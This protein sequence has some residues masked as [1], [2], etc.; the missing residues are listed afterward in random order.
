MKSLHDYHPLVIFIYFFAV[1]GLTMFYMHPLLLTISFFGS[2]ILSLFIQRQAFLATAKWILPFMFIAALLNPLLTHDGEIILLYVNEQP[3]T[4]EAIVYGFA[5]SMML[6]SVIFWFGSFN[7]IMTSD[8]FLYVFAKISPAVALLISLT[9]RLIP[10]FTHQIKRITNAQKAIGMDP[11]TGSLWH[12]IKAA[13]RIISILISWALENAIETADSMKARGYGLKNRSTFSLF[14]FDKADGFFVCIVTILF[15]SQVAFS[16]FGWNHFDYYPTFSALQWDF[17]TIV[18]TF[19]Y[20]LLI[21]L[22]IFI[23]IQEAFKWRSLKSI[24]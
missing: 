22:P 8:K 5:M 3:I 12:R 20:T 18:V 10:L 19:S 2:I 16:Y 7:K 23:E 15:C 6:V 1:I 11:S 24:N 17:H 21:A 4:L 9:M 14:R 13:A